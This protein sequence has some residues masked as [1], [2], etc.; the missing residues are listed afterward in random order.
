MKRLLA[1]ALG[2]GALCTVALL[3]RGRGAGGRAGNTDNAGAGDVE[4]TGTDPRVSRSDRGAGLSEHED[5]PP[6]ATGRAE[7]HDVLGAA[8]AL[9]PAEAQAARA[10]ARHVAGKN[11]SQE[12]EGMFDDLNGVGEAGSMGENPQH[13]TSRNPVG[14]HG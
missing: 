5:A 12:R 2:L 8:H 3:R 1:A 9:S 7:G 10:A 13:S 11:T 14:P 6:L 4:N